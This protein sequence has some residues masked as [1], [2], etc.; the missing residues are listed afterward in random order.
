MTQSLVL[1][2]WFRT[3]E[4]A[5][6]TRRRIDDPVLAGLSIGAHLQPAGEPHQVQH[7]TNCIALRRE[8]N[9]RVQ[10]YHCHRLH[11]PPPGGL[12]QRL[13]LLGSMRRFSVRT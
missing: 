5:H 7:M 13:F 1:T 6:H 11:S 9:T 8:A 10:S 4:I 2:S 3:S 12:A